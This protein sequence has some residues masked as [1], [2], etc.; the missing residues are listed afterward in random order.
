MTFGMTETGFNPK[1]LSDILAEAEGDLALIEDPESGEFLAP[2]FNSDDP[3]MQVVKVPL[4]GVGE[5]WEMAAIVYSQFDPNKAIG[6]ALSSLMQLNGIERGGGSPSTAPVLCVGTPGTPIPAGSIISDEAL[7]AR[8]VIQSNVTIGLGGDVSAVVATSEDG[9]FT[10]LAATLTRIITPVPGWASVSNPDAAT[11]G[12]AVESDP[13]A[14]ARR[15]NSTM[16]PASAPAEAIWA[17]LSN[18]DGVTYARVYSNKAL[19]TDVRGIP[20]KAIAAVIVG[21]D[22][23]E[24]ARVLLARSSTT[25]DWFGDVSVNLFDLQGEAYEIKFSRPTAVDIWV[26][27]DTTVDTQRNTWPSDG[28][29][30]IKAAIILYAAQGADAFGI[31]TSA[32]NFEADGFP[33]GINISV[34]PLYVP[35]NSVPGHNITRLEIGLAM[36]VVGVADLPIAFNEVGAFDTARITVAAT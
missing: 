29:D 32:S 8:W 20:G 10:A 18:L 1:R 35:A 19:T 2:D 36:G 24:I 27:I 6:A 31:D 3:A 15:D 23:T 25:S 4:E 9:A 26:E 28:A 34:G 14:R 5:G 30:R 7:T 13:D 21:G 33:P 22:D 17:N 11:P 16:A 12:V